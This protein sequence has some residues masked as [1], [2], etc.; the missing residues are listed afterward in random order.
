VRESRTH[1]TVRGALRNERPYRDRPARRAPEQGYR[2]S[3]RAG[4]RPAVVRP[5]RTLCQQGASPCGVVVTP[6]AAESNCVAARRGG[7]QLEANE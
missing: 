4:R 3:G 6:R 5:L 2:K 7:K 1:G